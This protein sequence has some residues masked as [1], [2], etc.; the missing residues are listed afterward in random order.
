[1]PIK[2]SDVHDSVPAFVLASVLLATLTAGGWMALDRIRMAP[3]TALVAGAAAAV[4]SPNYARS[5]AGARLT[6]A[7]ESETGPSWE[8]LGT[9]QQLALYPLAERWVMI[10][11][12]QKRRWLA[13]AVNFSAL[14]AAEQA[15]V[16]ERMSEWAN[17]SAQQRNQARLN[18][19]V[20]SRL[21][22]DDKRAQWEAYQALSD[23]ERA[24]LAAAAQPKPKGAATALSPVPAKKLAQ[25]P[26][27]VQ[28]NPERPNAP[29]IPPVIDNA[30]RVAAPVSPATLQA[31]GAP[32]PAPASTVVE[33]APVATPVAV[34][35]PLP[36][37]P[38]TAEAAAAAPATPAPVTPDNSGLYPQ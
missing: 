4:A 18:Y 14:P 7:P 25:V 22:L 5:T 27:A 1:M 31:P 24:A 16:H 13:L 36:A 35:A 38:E 37:I 11:E 2:S 20:T 12:A 8:S 10:S 30:P 23:A 33:T 3:G 21:G 19:A 17:L 15:K 6:T 26:A 9:A 34:P 28:A 32:Q 29:K